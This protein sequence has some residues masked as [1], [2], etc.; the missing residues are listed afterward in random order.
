MYK[1]QSEPKVTFV[2]QAFLLGD[3][4]CSQLGGCISGSQK[5]AHIVK[6]CV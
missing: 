6:V 2:T 5:H 1:A 3:N 4:D